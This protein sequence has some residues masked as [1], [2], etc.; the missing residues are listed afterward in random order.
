MTDLNSQLVS[1][2]E[3]TIDPIIS[4]TRRYLPG[5]G[6]GDC[7]IRPIHLE[8]RSSASVRHISV[9]C[10]YFAQTRKNVFGISK[11]SEKSMLVAAKNWL[12]VQ[13][14]FGL[15]SNNFICMLSN[16]ASCVGCLGS[17]LILEAYC[18]DSFPYLW[19]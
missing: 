2:G 9:E 4:R 19:P 10:N 5:T 7:R 8:E 6:S 16:T 14:G 13:M 17:D 18:R 1:V 3:A 11:I 15:A 12:K